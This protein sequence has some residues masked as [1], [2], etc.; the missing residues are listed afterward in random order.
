MSDI[1]LDEFDRFADD[2]E[3]AANGAPWTYEP[4]AQPDSAYVKWVELCS[5]AAIRDLIARIRACEQSA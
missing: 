4:D 2:M 5:P 3:W 1:A